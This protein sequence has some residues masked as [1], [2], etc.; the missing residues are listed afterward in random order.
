MNTEKLRATNLAAQTAEALQAASEMV[1]HPP[2][3]YSAVIL[4]SGQSWETQVFASARTR[5]TADLGARIY[6]CA[7]NDE[8][9]VIVDVVKIGRVKDQFSPESTDPIY[10]DAYTLTLEGSEG[11]ESDPFD[12]GPGQ[13]F[14]LTDDTKA[15]ALLAALRKEIK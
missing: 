13:K 2:G 1:R 4:F 11:E 3:L 5:S 8:R 9:L 14:D 12:V 15:A 7:K 6:E 10:L